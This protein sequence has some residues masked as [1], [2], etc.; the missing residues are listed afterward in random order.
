[1]NKEVAVTIFILLT[2]AFSL[3][4]VFK[5]SHIR[6]CKESKGIN[7]DLANQILANNGFQTIVDV[8]IPFEF[9]LAH[10]PQAISMP[11][12]TI[13]KLSA[14]TS[15]NSKI[16]FILIYGKTAEDAM[17]GQMVISKLGYKNVYYFDGS[18]NLLKM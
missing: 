14:E 3:F 2:I 18:S 6:M 10:Y 11:L 7:P 8:R 5:D 4:F 9:N 15:L 16:A 17:R 1:M 12:T 13:T